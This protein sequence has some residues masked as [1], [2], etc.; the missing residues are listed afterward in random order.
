MMEKLSTIL[1]IIF[2]IFYPLINSYAEG[3]DWVVF[4]SDFPRDFIDAN[5]ITSPEKGIVRFWERAGNRIEKTMKGKITYATYIL[6]EMNCNLKQMRI[7]N[8][9]MALEEQSPNHQ[10]IK[11]RARFLESRTKL[12]VN[13]PTPWESIEPN[14]HSYARLNYIC[15]TL[16]TK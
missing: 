16:Q 2:T 8:E 7:I 6:T 3:P 12:Q 4:D 1:I 10:A 14:M 15:K 11:A 9:D 5:S 13:Y